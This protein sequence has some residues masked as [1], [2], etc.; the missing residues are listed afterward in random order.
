MAEIP[1][2]P[3][4]LPLA[5]EAAVIAGATTTLRGGEAVET[6]QVP[7]TAKEETPVIDVHDAHHAASSWKEFFV[8][9]ATIVLG[10][11]IAVGLEQGVEWVH[12]RREVAAVR[13]ELRSERE[14]NKE[15]F[16]RETTTWRWEAVELEN[17]LRVLA[18]LK[19]HPGTADERLPG[20]LAWFRDAAGYREAAWDAAQ[21]SGVTSLMPREEVEGYELTYHELKAIS[22]AEG[23]MWESMINAFRYQLTDTRLSRLSPAQIAEITTSTQIAFTKLW[24]EGEALEYTAIEFRDFPP[25]ITVGELWGVLRL[26][27]EAER[28]QNPAYAATIERMRASGFVL[29]LQ[30]TAEGGGKR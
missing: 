27:S 7:E 22:D 5:E 26:P 6:A 2:M 3:E 12:H 28:E 9:I 16:Q 14:V 24:L 18:Y 10:L 11:L 20:S 1:E 23:L 17:N 21:S 4:E 30:F 13:E 29:P 25:S 8:H 19:E 15:L